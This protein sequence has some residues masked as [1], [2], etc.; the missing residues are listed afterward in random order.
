MHVRNRKVSIKN[1]H[2]QERKKAKKLH[3]QQ[4]KQKKMVKERPNILKITISV[5]KLK[6]AIKRLR[7]Y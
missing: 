4:N 7:F 6:S 3:N 2:R 1:R 5:N